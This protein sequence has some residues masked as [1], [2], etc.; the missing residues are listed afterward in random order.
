ML[1]CEFDLT[2]DICSIKHCKIILFRFR[3]KHH[4]ILSLFTNNSRGHH[5]IERV[6][7]WNDVYDAHAFSRPV[8]YFEVEAN[9]AVF[10][11]D[12]GEGP[13]AFS[14]KACEPGA[15]NPEDGLTVTQARGHVLTYM[16]V[17]I[18]RPQEHLA[19][20]GVL[21]YKVD[22]ILAIVWIKYLR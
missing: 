20:A 22:G 15:Q 2:W 11:I 13:L 5:D 7:V 3:S 21:G 1:N 17:S 9:W 19:T 10:R 8:S 14:S 16:P 6:L 12:Y 18:G 4:S